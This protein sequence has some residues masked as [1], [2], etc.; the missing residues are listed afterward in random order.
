MVTAVSYS[1][2][3]APFD[4][5]N[6]KSVPFFSLLWSSFTLF[7]R[8]YVTPDL[9]TLFL[10]MPVPKG[11]RKDWELQNVFWIKVCSSNP[12]LKVD[13]IWVRDK[14]CFPSNGKSKQTISVLTNAASTDYTF[15][16]NKEA[17]QLLMSAETTTAK[18]G[19]RQIFLHVYFWTDQTGYESFDHGEPT[20]PSKYKFLPSQFWCSGSKPQ[21]VFLKSV[22]AESL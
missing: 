17:K 13:I 19:I 6:L 2:R 11:F 15:C 18:S 16:D 5:R 12:T 22:H 1:K 8:L 3:Q 21:H 4:S 10:R 9:L 14:R 20:P 7:E